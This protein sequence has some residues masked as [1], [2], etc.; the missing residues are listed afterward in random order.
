MQRILQVVNIM[1]RGGVETL[2]MNIYRQIDRNEVQFDFLTHPF[3]L[4]YEQEYEPEILARGGKVY[5]APSFIKHP[6][7]YQRFIQNLYKE[8]PEYNVIHGHNLDLAATMYMREAK[9]NGRYLIAHSHNTKERG[10]VMRRSTLSLNHRLIRRYPDRFF[11]CS[12]DAAVFAFG[13][14][15]AHSAKCRIIRNGVDIQQYRADQVSHEKMKQNMF[16]GVSG[17]LFGTVGRLAEQKNHVFLLNIFADIIRNEPTAFLVI[18]G[19]GPLRAILERKARELN[20][21]SRILFAGSVSNVAAYLKAFDVFLMPSLYEGLP[22]SA[23]EAQAAGLPTLLSSSIGKETVCSDMVQ[24]IGLDQAPS[25]WAQEALQAYRKNLG[26]RTSCFDQVKLA[27]FDIT[28]ISK[29]LCDF[30]VAHIC[31]CVNHE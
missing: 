19:E 2:L 21:S 9:K 23:V 16:P 13:R 11:A 28:Q 5:K 14:R 20:I 1:D 6:V 4:D 18:I 7:Q 24:F 25:Q 27:G 26:R 3:N 12:K 15:V 30:Y 22:L 17:P 31:E 8:H 29:D 10:N